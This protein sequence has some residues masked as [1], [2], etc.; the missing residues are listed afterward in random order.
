VKHETLH[1]HDPWSNNYVDIKNWIK[2]IEQHASDNVNKILV[3]NKADMDESERVMNEICQKKK[4][5]SGVCFFPDIFITK[6][7]FFL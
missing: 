2:N 1:I 4:K 6:V 7:E 5:F 3:G